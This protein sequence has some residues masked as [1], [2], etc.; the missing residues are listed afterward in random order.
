MQI[1]IFFCYFK[2]KQYLCSRFRLRVAPLQVNVAN[3]RKGARVVE[4]ARLESE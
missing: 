1:Y 4:E 2:K 3:P